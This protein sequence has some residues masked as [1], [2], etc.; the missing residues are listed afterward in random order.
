MLDF[1]FLLLLLSSTNYYPNNNWCTT[2]FVLVGGFL[3]SSTSIMPS[4]QLLLR[5][6][7]LSLRLWTKR[8]D[9][10]EKVQSILLPIAECTKLASRYKKRLSF[11][12]G[13]R[14]RGS[15]KSIIV[16]LTWSI[17][18]KKTWRLPPC[19]CLLKISASEVGWPLSPTW[20]LVLPE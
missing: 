12:G 17:S 6:S 19:S 18:H 11:L 8:K 14:H 20:T 2:H 4:S 9:G 7:H 15:M 3:P 13:V 10:E 5:N 16:S 1:L